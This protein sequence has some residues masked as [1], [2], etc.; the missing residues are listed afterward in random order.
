MPHLELHTE[1]TLAVLLTQLTKLADLAAHLSHVVGDLAQMVS[2]RSRSSSLFFF[3]L[4]TP[5]AKEALTSREKP[6]SLQACNHYRASRVHA[7]VM[8]LY[9]H[10]LYT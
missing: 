7:R 10:V 2:M 6:V 4:L 9:L 1:H 3:S 8:Q 5:S